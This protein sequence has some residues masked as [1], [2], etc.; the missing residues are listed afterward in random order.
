MYQIYACFDLTKLDTC[1]LEFY[2]QYLPPERQSKALCFR[3]E[4]DKKNCVMAYL[5]LRYGLYKDY[6]IRTVR[7]SYRHTGKLYLSDHPNIHFSI[8][9]CPR[10]CICAISDSPIGIDIQD[11]HPFSWSIADH[12]CS[13]EEKQFLRECNDPAAEFTKIWTMKESYLKMKGTGIT[14]DLCTVDTTKLRDKIKTIAIND[15]YISVA[16]AESFQ[17]EEICLI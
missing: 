15:C 8:S 16:T 17:E 1:M 7:L 3:K 12:C 6:G 13:A 14:V 11:I 9:H 10:G 2:M 4:I 5:L